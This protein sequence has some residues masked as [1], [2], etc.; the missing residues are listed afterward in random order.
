MPFSSFMS[1]GEAASD[2]RKVVLSIDSFDSSHGM[3]PGALCFSFVS[4][5]GGPWAI[6]AIRSSQPKK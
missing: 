3:G 4:V 6:L 2:R 5:A 1:R